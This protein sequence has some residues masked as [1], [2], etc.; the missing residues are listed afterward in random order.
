[1]SFQS[2]AWPGALPWDGCPD[3]DADGLANS[4]DAC[5]TKAEDGLGP[6]QED[7]C[8]DADADGVR[9]DADL[10]PTQHEDQLPPNTHDG[11]PR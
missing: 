1:M 10:C 11:C 7:G 3:D 8:P 5:R 2:G 4:R 6:Q 9:D